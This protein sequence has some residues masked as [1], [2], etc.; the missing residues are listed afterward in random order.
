MKPVIAPPPTMAGVDGILT[1]ENKPTLVGTATP[2]TLAR[3]SV[4]DVE[5]GSVMVD[6]S[7]N[8]RFALPEQSDGV[9]V[10][11]VLAMN[12]A[13][14]YKTTSITMTIDTTPSAV[15]VI[16]S[17]V[18]NVG[19]ITGPL[20]S[21]DYTDDAAPVVNGKG[22]TSGDNVKVFDGETYLGS[23]TVDASGNWSYKPAAALADGAHH[24]QV[25]SV[26][27][28]RNESAKSAAFDLTVDTIAP[29][30]QAFDATDNVGP[31]TGPIGPN[32]STT[33]DSRP[34]F[35]GNSG[36]SEAGSTVTIY[37]LYDG[38]TSALGTATVGADGSWTFKPTVEMHD[39]AHSVT[40]KATDKAGNESVASDA[41]VFTTDTSGVN[42][43]ITGV[44]DSEGT[45]IA[46]PSG[47][48]DTTQKP[49]DT[50]Q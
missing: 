5:V 18:D 29:D 21:G 6:N 23:A 45:H 44:E 1:N 47:T 36:A 35:K 32:N 10:Y 22:A 12:D 17:V 39:G 41:L 34:V 40:V 46:N 49:D 11:K 4:D 15:P 16:D 37:D 42:V 3:V 28:A 9:H 24:L 30:K 48:P 38:N 2:N 50:T 43:Q 14:T 20:K 25:S 26:D 19:S 8:W 7:G 33:D 13:G 27:P 31:V